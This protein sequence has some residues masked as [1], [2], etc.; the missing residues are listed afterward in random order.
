MKAAAERQQLMLPAIRRS[1]I[2]RAPLSPL[3]LHATIVFTSPR[4]ASREFE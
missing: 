3:R 2:D 1:R 4:E